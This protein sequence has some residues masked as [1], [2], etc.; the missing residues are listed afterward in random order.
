MSKGLGIVLRSAPRRLWEYSRVIDIDN[1]AA[2][3]QSAD[4][5]TD[6]DTDTDRE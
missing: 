4:T 1:D 3:P 5:D 6:T 2:H